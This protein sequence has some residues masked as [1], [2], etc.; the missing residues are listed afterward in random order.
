MKYYFKGILR[1]LLLII[2]VGVVI[3]FQPLL[4]YM[5]DLLSQTG[6][7]PG[8]LLFYT[9]H[10]QGCFDIFAP[11][12][13]SIPFSAKFIDEY[14]DKNIYFILTRER[15]WKYCVHHIVIRLINGGLG[16]ALPNVILLIFCA[17]CGTSY[18][19]NDVPRGFST[20]F[21]NTALEPFQ[22]MLNGYMVAVIVVILSFVFGLIWSSIGVLFSAMIPNKYA[23]V[24]F[25]MIVYYFISLILYGIGANQYSPMAMIIPNAEG[26]ENLGFVFLFQLVVLTICVVSSYISMM[27][28]VKDV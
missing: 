4:R 26:I 23:A 1:E 21:Q 25:P 20:L 14:N 3:L 19:P 5:S 16:V 6:K 7:M 8:I 24:A 28:R 2:L 22:F 12:L 15:K 9:S 13:A 18:T 11:A 27:K 10:S 17:V